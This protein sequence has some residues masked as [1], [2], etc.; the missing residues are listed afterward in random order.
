MSMPYRV[1]SGVLLALV[2][3]L[4]MVGLA[5][6]AP[7]LL[8]AASAVLMVAL[9]VWLL[10]RPTWFAVEA[11]HLVIRWPL[12]E[13]RIPL[14]DIAQVRVLRGT[15]GLLEEVRPGFRLGAGGLFGTFGMLWTR[16]HGL[17]TA[18]MTRM[19]EGVFLGLRRG[20][21]ILLTPLEPER[22]ANLL[23]PAEAREAVVNVGAR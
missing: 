17:A 16:K 2:P 6:G 19:D 8:W 22:L 10:F 4:A 3:L 5:Q 11:D 12:R 7:A 15:R 9:T 23:T 18:Y 20:R 21:P 14:R 13:R 1:T